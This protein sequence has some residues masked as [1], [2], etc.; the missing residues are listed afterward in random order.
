MAWRLVACLC[1][2]G[3]LGCMPVLLSAVLAAGPK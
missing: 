3:W 2:A 1:W